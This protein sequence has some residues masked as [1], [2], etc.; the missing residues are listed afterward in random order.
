MMQSR[1]PFGLESQQS[2]LLQVAAGKAKK[3]SSTCQS[4]VVYESR[5]AV[6]LRIDE[7]FPPQPE[8]EGHFCLI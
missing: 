1:F 7:S 8:S 4:G 6:L 2:D 3:K 5:E